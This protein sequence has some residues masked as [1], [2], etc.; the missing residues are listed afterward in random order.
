MYR[1]APLV[2]ILALA[3]CPGSGGNDPAPSAQREVEEGGTVENADRDR[4][5]SY[6]QSLTK[7]SSVEEERQV[8]QEFATWLNEHSYKL[9]VE[10]KDGA[11][12]LACPYFPPVTP[13][14]EHTFLDAEHLK[15]LPQLDSSK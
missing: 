6:L 11:H 1:Y 4:A 3:G 8:V 13:W 9:E 7:A 14:A 5:E 2:L 10:E 15:L 12:V